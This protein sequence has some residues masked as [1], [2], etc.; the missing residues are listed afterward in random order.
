MQISFKSGTVLKSFITICSD[1][2]AFKFCGKYLLNI[3]L[4]YLINPNN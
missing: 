3:Q 2:N 4:K 1:K